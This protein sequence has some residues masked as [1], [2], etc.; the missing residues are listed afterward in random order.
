MGGLGGCGYCVVLMAWMMGGPSWI[1]T[2]LKFVR[3]KG[4]VKSRCTRGW[5]VEAGPIAV[6]PRLVGSCLR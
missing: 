6:A 4:V 3:Y 5:K 2:A 1:G